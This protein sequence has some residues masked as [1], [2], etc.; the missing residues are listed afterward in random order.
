MRQ[1]R[2]ASADARAADL[3]P[4]VED[5]RAAGPNSLGDIARELNTRDI[6]APW[7]GQWSAAQVRLL[8][9]RLPHLSLGQPRSSHIRGTNSAHRPS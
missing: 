5:I 4:V 9:K 3:A 1:A 2:S 8:F 7:G 6:S